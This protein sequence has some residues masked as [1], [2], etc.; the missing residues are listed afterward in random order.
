MVEGS[1][2]NWRISSSC[3]NSDCVAIAMMPDGEVW[4]RQTSNENGILRFSAAEWQDFLT[5]V[6][7]GRADPSGL[8]R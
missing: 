5:G 2:P 1:P 7:D 4:M 8:R 6:R 3:V